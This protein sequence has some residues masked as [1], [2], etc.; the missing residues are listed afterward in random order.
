MSDF[1]KIRYVRPKYSRK[2]YY[3]LMKLMQDGLAVEISDVAS[4]RI[5]VL[6]H[7]YKYGLTPTL[8]AFRIKKSTFYDWK[9]TYETNGK[10]I[11]SLVPKKTRPINV[12][13]MET[14]WRVT[15][16]IREMRKEHG[17]IGK[18]ML[19]PF[20]DAYAKE[21]GIKTLAESTI[22]KVIKRRHLTFEK[23]VYPQKQKNKFK[24][25][26]TRKSPKVTSSGFIQ[27]DSI[28]VYI[29]YEKHL[30]MSVIDIYTK[31]AQVTCV[32]N[33]SSATARE[34]FKEFQAAN[35]TPIHTIQTDN[36]SEFLK[37]FHAYL[38]EKKIKHQFIYP[39]MPKINAFIERFNRTIQEE[40]I[41][42]SD[43]IYYDQVAFAKKLTEYLYWYNYKRPH[44][45]L[46]YMSPMDFIETKIPKSA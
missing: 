6:N 23:K 36:G 21:L 3:I 31:F 10:R 8:D 29:N 24:K 26:R 38:E 42:R 18:S 20:V 30:F 35:P 46:K 19:K 7:Y 43:E 13:R 33:L 40:F 2:K 37:S 41:L 45:S 27:M 12:R 32:K 44:A 28:V 9:K 17:N 5:H 22:G 15:D 39:G 25:L 34:V 1:N 11:I 14:D 4:F 16:F